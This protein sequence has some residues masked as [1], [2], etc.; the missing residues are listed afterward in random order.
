MA[1]GKPKSAHLPAAS[2]PTRA[3]TGRQIVGGERMERSIADF[4]RAC[5]CLIVDEQEE[6][7]PDN[8][9]ISV[10]CDA[11]RLTREME[12]MAQ[13]G[14]PPAEPSGVSAEQVCGCRTCR[15]KA[16]GPQTCRKQ[17]IQAYG[18]ARE[19][20]ARKQAERDLINRMEAAVSPEI[21]TLV[22]SAVWA[23][24]GHL[25]MTREEARKQEREKALAIIRA[26]IT[27]HDEVDTVDGYQRPCAKPGAF[28]ECFGV[29]TLR[30]L[31][32]KIERGEVG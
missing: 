32:D 14:V 3:E 4:V 13:G 22:P 5:E 25:T 30:R 9:L 7:S 6:A 15:G 8:A 27:E 11:V 26:E 24:I 31:A 2:E 29:G 21:K 1:S 28:C 12:R 16:K 18:D 20:E 19:R 23:M 10:L 17:A